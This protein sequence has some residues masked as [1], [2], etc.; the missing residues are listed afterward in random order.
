MILMMEVIKKVSNFGEDDDNQ[1]LFTVFNSHD[2]CGDND[3]D[4]DEDDINKVMMITLIV[5]V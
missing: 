4:E 1:Y 5:K 3:D 2:H